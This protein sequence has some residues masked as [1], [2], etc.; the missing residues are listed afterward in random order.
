[1]RDRGWFWVPG[2]EWGPAWVSWRTGGDSI[3][4]APIPPRGSTK[5]SVGEPGGLAQAGS[6]AGL[7]ED[8][9]LQLRLGDGSLAVVCAGEVRLS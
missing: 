6:F 5:L 7:T 8:G 9:L 3:G 2:R 1:M 4:W